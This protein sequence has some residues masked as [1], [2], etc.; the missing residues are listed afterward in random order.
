MALGEMVTGLVKPVLDKFIP[1][2]KDR[3]EAEQMITKAIVSTDLAQIEVNKEEAKSESLFVAGWRPFIGWVCGGA[4]AY[5]FVV[6]PFFIF[7]VTVFQI[8]LKTEQL[9]HLNWSE[10]GFVLAGM[11]G[12]STLRSYEKT[13]K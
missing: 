9:P 5:T 12:L 6:Q 1:D 11:L 8:P 13:K 2:A 7:V 10:L 4:Y 3:L